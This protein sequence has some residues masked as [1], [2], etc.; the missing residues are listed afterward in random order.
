MVYFR[1]CMKT[2]T[3]DEWIRKWQIFLNY[4]SQRILGEPTSHGGFGTLFA[5]RVL[6][7]IDAN[8]NSPKGF[9]DAEKQIIDEIEEAVLSM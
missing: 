2:S 7:I 5:S 9:K 3:P 8:P 4:M 1:H 6:E